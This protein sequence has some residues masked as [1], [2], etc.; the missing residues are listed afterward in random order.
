MRVD[1]RSFKAKFRQQIRWIAGP[2]VNEKGAR[3][4]EWLTVAQTLAVGRCTVFHRMLSVRDDMDL[5]WSSITERPV[6]ARSGCRF[7]LV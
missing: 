1:P 7:G 6:L 2:S 3:G 5:K 4:A